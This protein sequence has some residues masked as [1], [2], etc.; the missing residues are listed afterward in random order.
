MWTVNA[1]AARS[2]SRDRKAEDGDKKIE[3]RTSWLNSNIFKEAP[4]DRDAL[5]ALKQLD[6]GRAMQLLQQVADKQ[7]HIRNPAAYLKRAA[8]TSPRSVVA[9][10][11]PSVGL[12]PRAVSLVPNRRLSDQRLQSISFDLTKV[13]RYSGESLGCF[14]SRQ[15][16]I[17]VRQVLKLH[18]FGNRTD[19]SLT[20]EELFQI[21]ERDAKNRF[22]LKHDDDLWIRATTKRTIP[23]RMSPPLSPVHVADASD[24]LPDEAVE[25]PMVSDHGNDDFPDEGVESEMEIESEQSWN[26]EEEEHSDHR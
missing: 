26:P 23:K 10:H 6:T 1:A 24:D 17:P 3:R 9:S 18:C 5:A 20:T 12:A 19:G 16:F 21:V 2:R 14:V 13:L 11:R 25:S 4:I 8:T 15:G 7:D 22:E